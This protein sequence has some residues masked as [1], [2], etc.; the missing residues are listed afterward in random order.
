MAKIKKTGRHTGAIEAFRQSLRKRAGNIRIKEAVK[1]LRKA[2]LKAVADKD[3]TK[4]QSLLVECSSKL[5]KAAKTNVF[6]WRNAGRKKSFLAR[7]V[8]QLL[9]TVG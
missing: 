3:K 8:N 7:Q 9:K 1:V 6:H 4:A 5:D 2:L